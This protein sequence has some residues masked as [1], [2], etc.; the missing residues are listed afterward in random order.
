MS[1]RRELKQKATN[2][3]A[4]FWSLVMVRNQLPA[5]LVEHTSTVTREISI[6]IFRV[7]ATKP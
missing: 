3:R 5:Q 4:R 7:A 1:Y 2:Y 6:L